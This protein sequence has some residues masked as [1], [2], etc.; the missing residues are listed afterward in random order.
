[1]K[2]VVVLQHKNQALKSQRFTC[3]MITFF[4]CSTI[5]VESEARKYSQEQEARVWEIFASNE[6]EGRCFVGRTL[7][8]FE[9]GAFPFA[10]FMPNIIG[11]PLLTATSSAG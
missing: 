10:G 5:A 9:L 11:E 7:T 2:K 3:S 1:M 8:W 4:V 6:A